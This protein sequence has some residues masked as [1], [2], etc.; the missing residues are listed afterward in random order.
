MVSGPE[1]PSAAR[2]PGVGCWPVVPDQPSVE[3]LLNALAGDRRGERAAEARVLHQH[4]NGDCCNPKI[5]ICVL[6]EN[7]GFGGSFAAPIAGQCIEQYL[8][9]RLIR[10]DRPAPKPQVASQ[11][12][13]TPPAPKPQVHAS[14]VLSN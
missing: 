5:A 9:G 4:A 3:I 12:K 7:A 1:V 2:R 14:S 10:N 6:V 8:Y 11:P 13:E